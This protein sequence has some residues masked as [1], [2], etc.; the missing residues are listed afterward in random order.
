MRPSEQARKTGDK[1]WVFLLVLMAIAVVSTGFGF[2]DDTTTLVS[3][4]LVAIFLMLD[5]I[6]GALVSILEQLED[7]D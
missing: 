6:H 4:L 2:R 1:V 5:R 3:S 7:E